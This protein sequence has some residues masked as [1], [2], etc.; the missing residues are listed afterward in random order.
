MTTTLQVP[1]GIS[2][3]DL[4][5]GTVAIP[6]SHGQIIVASQFVH[7]LLDAGFTLVIPADG[8]EWYNFASQSGLDL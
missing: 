5:D 6:D 7:T 3:V 1:P 4:Q 2:T 8:Q